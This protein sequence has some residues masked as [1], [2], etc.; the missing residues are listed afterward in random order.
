MNEYPEAI[1]NAISRTSG[2]RFFRCA[3]QVNPFDYLARHNKTTQYTSESEYNEALVT[4]CQEEGID[5]IGVTDHYR[6]RTARSLIECAQN[7][8]LRVLPGFEAVTKDGV[9]FLCLFSPN[10]PLDEIDRCIGDCGIHDDQQASPLGQWDVVEFLDKAKNNWDCVCIAAHVAAAGGLLKKLSGKTS[11]NAWT[12][13]ELLA[14]ALPGPISAAPDNIRPILQNKN[15]DYFRDYPVAIVNASDVDDPEALRRPETSCSLKMTEVSLDGLRQAFFDPSS[16]IR[17]ASDSAP[18][19]HAEFV[20]LAWE[21][22]FLGGETI[23]FNE[24]LNVLVGGRGTGKSTV[25]ESLRYVL[26]SDALGSDAQ[27]LQKGFLQQVLGPGTKVT[28]LVRSYSPSRREYVITRNVNEEP[29]VRDVTGALTRLHPRDVLPHVQVFGQH[30]ISELAKDNEKLTH[31]LE[32]FMPR[33]AEH[34]TRKRTLLEELEDTRTEILRLGKQQDR[35]TEQLSALPALEEQLERFRDAGFEEKL[36]EQQDLVKEAAALEKGESG[37]ASVKDL[38]RELDDMIP[39][40]LDF[41]PRRTQPEQDSSESS[42]TENSPEDEAAEE[43]SLQNVAGAEFLWE[44]REAIERMCERIVEALSPVSEAID[45]C[46]ATLA[47]VRNRWNV[48][49]EEVHDSYQK[50]LR[51]LQRTH[52]NADAQAFVSIS[53]RVERLRPSKEEKKSLLRELDAANSKRREALSRWEDLK[54]EEFRELEKA[55][56]RVKKSLDGLVR[57]RVTFAGNREPLRRLLQEHVEGRVA[58]AVDKILGQDELSLQV[59]AASA[60]EGQATLIEKFGLTESQAARIASAGVEAFMHLEEVELPATTSIEL[61]VAAS[62]DAVWK[63][64]EELSTGQKAT[65]I[66][67]LLLLES[68]APLVIDQ[69]EDDL[70]NRFVT[71]GIVPRIKEEKGRRQ[72]VFATHNANVPVLGDAELIVGLVAEGEAGG[73]H[74]KL[75]DEFM[76]SIDVQSVCALVAEVLEGGKE[77][78]DTRRRKYR[79]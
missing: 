45:D 67:L 3:L 71:E 79:F 43:H 26:S 15:P 22:G 42:E 68:D 47:D 28:L 36:K 55:A 51:A 40:E 27:K 14:A 53:E 35:V 9:H 5:V 50:I 21:G 75:P 38:V 32:R 76:G 73:G 61:N 74:G 18:D 52:S 25:I 58:E 16:R 8:G 57:V 29:E 56:K 63:P 46:E 24:N 64:L 60:R 33:N 10:R 17:L 31:L 48:R 20:A 77:A 6:V 34:E 78:F 12:H 54:R 44:A 39:V 13:A 65:A 19:C 69:P 2:A 49:R 70:D 30:E 1:Q 72:F 37:V 4:V 23:H 66:L 41:F 62:G 7:A 59:L 11:I